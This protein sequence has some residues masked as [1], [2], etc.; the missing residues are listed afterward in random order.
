MPT[1]PLTDAG[2]RALKPRET[3]YKVADG[4]G[5]HLLITP[6]GGKLWR[7]AYRYGG[8]QKL[9]AIGAYPKVGLGDAR[10]AREQA[11]RQ[12]AA[13]EDPSAAKKQAKLLA[14]EA[15][16]NTFSAIAE[17]WHKA[18]RA[19]WTTDYGDRIW[20]R[21]QE[22]VLPEIG[23]LP[24][25]EIE[26]PTLLAAIRKIEARGTIELAARV[27]N[28][29]GQVFRYAIAEGLATRDP[30]ADIR[31]ALKTKPPVKHRAALKAKDLPEFFERLE[32]YDGAPL[33]ALA[34]RLALLT[35]VR[36][37]ELR[38]AAWSELEDL[39]GK[40]PLWRIPAARMKG[41]ASRKREHLVP[42]SPQAVDVL[43]RIRE[44][45]ASPDL[46]FAAETRA[47][48]ISENTMLYAL[49]RMGYQSRAT[50]HGFRGTAST[51][52]NENGFRS[53]LIETQLAHV[54]RNEVRAAYN[55][56]AWLPERR[57]MMKWWAD[58]LDKLAE[59]AKLVG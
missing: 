7:L 44:V 15:A 29:C 28:Y 16:G 11:K 20:Q 52:L 46:L 30:S 53:D 58:Y 39:A 27:K 55:S 45:Q 49:Y 50:V 10:L 43:R 1:T 4:G 56:A 40:E 48:V 8:K 35:F 54:E 5:L 41:E 51:I 47:G 36:T 24:I 26:P 42:L 25:A 37:D 31:E 34:I 19:R 21:V 38:F 14:K 9:L 18:R 3:S 23:A 33:T 59:V 2:V 22:H 57:A 17:R 6:A 32:R 12:I 13:G